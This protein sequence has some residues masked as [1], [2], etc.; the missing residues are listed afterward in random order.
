MEPQQR[1]CINFVVVHAAACQVV[2]LPRAQ[3]AIRKYC[4]SNLLDFMPM[5]PDQPARL[6]S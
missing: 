6:P 1:R 2:D 5:S 3:F 4:V